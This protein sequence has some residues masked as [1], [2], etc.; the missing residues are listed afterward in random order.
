MWGVILFVEIIIYLLNLLLFRWSGFIGKEYLGDALR[1]PISPL[2]EKYFLYICS[3]FREKSGTGFK[4]F[5]FYDPNCVDIIRELAN[6]CSI[7]CFS[8]RLTQDFNLKNLR[9]AL[10]GSIFSNCWVVLDKFNTLPLDI[11][12]I[13]CK[14]IL[15]LQ[16]KYILAEINED[17]E[18]NRKILIKNN[19][20]YKNQ[21]KEIKIPQEELN[22]S[23]TISNNS[24]LNSNYF[25]KY[26]SL[27]GENAIIDFYEDKEKGVAIPSINKKKNQKEVSRVA[28]GLFI[29]YQES[30]TNLD[31]I[32]IKMDKTEKFQSMQ[33]CFR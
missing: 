18:I 15:V 31:E 24:Q 14:E 29:T 3:S 6:M 30:I 16:Q 7:A 20:E 9:L 27:E 5:N 1:Y 25:K 11:I 28:H 10:F 21:G 13:I 32:S 19:E 22:Y 8:F 2:S 17:H 12:Q 26:E 23:Q 4:S 33:S